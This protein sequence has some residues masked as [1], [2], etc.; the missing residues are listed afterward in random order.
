V[1]SDDSGLQATGWQQEAERILAMNPDIIM[2]NPE[3][4]YHDPRWRGLDAVFA[5]MTAIPC[6]M[7]M[8]TTSTTCRCQQEIFHPHMSARTR[9]KI[10]AHYREPTVLWTMGNPRHTEENKRNRRPQDSAGPWVCDNAPLLS[11]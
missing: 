1:G 4:L 10:R 5:S 9:E 8:F 7:A 11:G 6:S 2:R 3:D